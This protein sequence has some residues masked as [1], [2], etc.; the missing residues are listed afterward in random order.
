MSSLDKR[1][2]AMTTFLSLILLGIAV[3]ELLCCF[4]IIKDVASLAQWKLI[5]YYLLLEQFPSLTISYFFNEGDQPEESEDDVDGLYSGRSGDYNYITK[6]KARRRNRVQTS[7]A[8]SSDYRNNGINEIYQERN[9]SEDSEYGNF[10]P[11]LFAHKRTISEAFERSNLHN[12]SSRNKIFTDHSASSWSQSL[13]N[14]S[15]AK[16]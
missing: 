12:Q 14:N 1:I 4:K 5:L 16:T 7:P 8:G 13:L 15:A 11:N 6:A 9:D 3:T 2:F 10:N